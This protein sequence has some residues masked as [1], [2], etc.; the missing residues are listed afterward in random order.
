MTERD[1]VFSWL[2]LIFSFAIDPVVTKD[3]E[4]VLDK[5]CGGPP[6][7]CVGFLQGT[8]QECLQLGQGLLAHVSI[9]QDVWTL[10]KTRFSTELIKAGGNAETWLHVLSRV[11]AQQPIFRES[12]CN[13]RSSWC[14]PCSRISQKNQCFVLHVWQQGKDDILQ[15]PGAQVMHGEIEVEGGLHKT[16]PVAYP[17]RDSLTKL[18]FQP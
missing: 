14:F 5:F 16:L 17:L 2:Q 4:L 10:T 3:P 18:V 9:I 13:C 7:D 1:G 6:F 11:T 12:H 8:I 15:K